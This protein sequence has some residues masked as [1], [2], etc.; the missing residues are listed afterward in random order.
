MATDNHV[1]PCTE[2]K[3]VETAVTQLQEQVKTL[4]EPPDIPKW[5]NILLLGGG[6]LF[7]SVVGYWATA[8]NDLND[9]VTRMETKLEHVIPEMSKDIGQLQASVSDRYYRTEASKDFD[10]RD[11]AIQGNTEA[12][13]LILTKIAKNEAAIDEMRESR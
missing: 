11:K 4:V 6:V 5:V 1:T 12:I 7:A 2:L 9:A 3:N 13:K 10:L 8:I